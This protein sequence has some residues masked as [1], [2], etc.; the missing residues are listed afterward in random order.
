[1]RIGD[2]HPHSWA[3]GDGVQDRLS[4]T[5]SSFKIHGGGEFRGRTVFG[6]GLKPKINVRF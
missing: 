4:C 6:H 5:P 3:A 1:M 2:K